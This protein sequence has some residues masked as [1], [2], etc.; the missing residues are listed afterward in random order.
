MDVSNDERAKRNHP[1][2][3]EMLLHAVKGVVLEK[4]EEAFLDMFRG[5]FVLAS[6]DDIAR[7]RGFLSRHATLPETTALAAKIGEPRC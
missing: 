5:A 4:K 6:E 1:V 3:A 7:I 2:P